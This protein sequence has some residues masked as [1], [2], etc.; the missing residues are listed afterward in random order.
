MFLNF[1]RNFETDSA[2]SW[3]ILR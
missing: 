1:F 3:N 2:D